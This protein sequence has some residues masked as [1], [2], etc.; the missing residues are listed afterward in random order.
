MPAKSWAP[1][2]PAVFWARAAG[3]PAQLRDSVS[4]PTLT[5]G[6]LQVAAVPHKRLL[7]EIRPTW[8]ERE[9]EA[10]MGMLMVPASLW[11]SARDGPRVQELCL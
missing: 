4:W 9:R 7:A 1:R 2:R 11:E 3:P 10:L 6:S 5:Q 8:G